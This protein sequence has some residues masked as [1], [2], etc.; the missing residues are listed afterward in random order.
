MLSFL[1]S[2]EFEI[3]NTPSNTLTG[4]LTTTI[5]PSL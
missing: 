3:H 4:V 1:E 2:K 5:F